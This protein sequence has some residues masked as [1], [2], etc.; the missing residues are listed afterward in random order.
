MDQRWQSLEASGGV[1]VFYAIQKS[2]LLVQ[3]QLNSLLSYMG[4]LV[5]MDVSVRVAL[6]D[7]AGGRDEFIRLRGVTGNDRGVG[8]V[9]GP[10]IGHRRLQQP[11][12]SVAESYYKNR[13][14]SV[15]IRRSHFEFVTKHAAPDGPLPL[16][17]Y[18]DFSMDHLLGGGARAQARLAQLCGYDASQEVSVVAT[19]YPI[20]NPYAL[21]ATRRGVRYFSTQVDA[22]LSAPQQT[23]ET[24]VI[25]LEMKTLMENTN[26]K[27]R[28]LY[29]KTFSQAFTNAVLFQEQT[30][31]RVE[32]VL[33]LYLTRRSRVYSAYSR[34]R[35]LM[36]QRSAL[37]AV[38]QNAMQIRNSALLNPV[39]EAL[40]TV[41]FD[42]RTGFA[43]TNL[44][45]AGYTEQSDRPMPALPGCVP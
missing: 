12:A 21:F 17:E 18:T 7:N 28:I 6:Y 11:P 44:L 32:G 43:C 8:V 19:E 13:L 22:V 2:S 5:H 36:F 20:V 24:H 29:R 25:V 39:R 15:F 27:D 31:L 16:R 1:D 34:M 38:H 30:G 3:A 42:G 26:P 41:Y 23:G 37:H 4:T 40:A 45:A 10:A 9:F 14:G 33:V 35:T